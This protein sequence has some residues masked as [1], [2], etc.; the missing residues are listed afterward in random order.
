M[1]K[2]ETMIISYFN[3]DLNVNI[4]ISKGNFVIETKWKVQRLTCLTNQYH[5]CIGERVQVKKKSVISSNYSTLKY[6]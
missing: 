2:Y 3:I 4:D 5:K 1:R 6:T